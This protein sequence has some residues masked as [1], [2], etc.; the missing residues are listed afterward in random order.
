M[1][2]VAILASTPLAGVVPYLTFIV[3]VATA[4]LLMLPAPTTESSTGY[5]AA[6]GL[7][8][9]VG[10]LRPQP[11]AKPPSSTTALFLCAALA[12]LSVAACTPQQQQYLRVACDVDGAMVA[13]G[14]PILVGLA[15]STS[16]IVATDLALVHPAVM[17]ACAT[18]N[19]KPAAVTAP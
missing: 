1:D 17:A 7:V 5:K 15:P 12:S 2:L 11:I 18:L 13:L 14:A 10:N 19:G 8:H 6:Y 3:T 9:M 4:A 16:D